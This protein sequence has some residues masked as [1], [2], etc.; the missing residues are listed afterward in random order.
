M[1]PII[2]GII[3]FIIFCWAG[4]M[5]G[6][7]VILCVATMLTTSAIG[8]TNHGSREDRSGI[9]SQC[10]WRKSSVA[11]NMLHALF[12]VQVRNFLVH[13]LFARIPHAVLLIFLLDRFNLRRD[14][15]HL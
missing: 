2:R 6:C 14:S 15:L 11:C 5:L 4:S 10:A 7:G 3:T 8:S 1:K 9:H 13:L 12:L